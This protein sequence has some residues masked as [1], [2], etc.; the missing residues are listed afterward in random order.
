VLAAIIADD[1]CAHVWLDEMDGPWVTAETVAALT[2]AGKRVW[3]VSPELH[4]PQPLAAL[5][6]RWT[7]AL[8]WGVTAICTDHPT[9][10]AAARRTPA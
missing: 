1:A 6:D 3:Y 7:E 9:A 5:H 10:L 4:R 8:A 2:G